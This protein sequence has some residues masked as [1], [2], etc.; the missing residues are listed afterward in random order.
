M[1]AT[2]LKSFALAAVDRKIRVNLAVCGR[3]IMIIHK[4]AAFVRI[5]AAFVRTTI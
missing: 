1:D 4:R 5:F 2:T 3:R